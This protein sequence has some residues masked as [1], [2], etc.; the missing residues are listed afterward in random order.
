MP[1]PA[2]QVVVQHEEPARR[3]SPLHPPPRITRTSL[4]ILNT[5][6]LMPLVGQIPTS[7]NRWQSPWESRSRVLCR[8][9]SLPLGLNCTSSL[10]H[11]RALTWL[12]CFFL[13]LRLRGTRRP[14]PQSHSTCICRRG[15]PPA[16]TYHITHCQRIHA[17]PIDWVASK[18]TSS[19][20]PK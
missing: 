9:P 18:P 7:N 8:R 5:A 2:H 15:R 3:C 1:M 20:L 10:A 12:S 16:C 6:S 11:R 17:Y 13:S 14:A 4:H 19:R